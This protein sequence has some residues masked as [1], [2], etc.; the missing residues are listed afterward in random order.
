MGNGFFH[1]AH[2]FTKLILLLFL[3]LA[4]YLVLFGL[5]IFLAIAIY[6]IPAGEVIS[7]IDNNSYEGNIPLLKMLQVL[8]STGLFL[9]PAILAAFLIERRVGD[10]LGLSG[11]P[12]IGIFL[13]ILMLMFAIVPFINY[14]ALLNEKL[15]LPAR[16]SGVMEKINRNDQSQWDLMKAF[17]DTDR[18]GGFLFNLFMIALVPAIGEEFFFRGV[19]QRILAE[20]F[21]N[22][23]VAIW[24][25]A[26]VFSLM[27]YQFMGFIPRIVLGAL[28]GYLF[29]WTGSIWAPVIAH[30]LNNGAAVVQYYFYYRG[31]FPQEPENIGLGDGA[32]QYVL[33]STL[34]SAVILL[35]IRKLGKGSA[36]AQLPGTE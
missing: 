31:N 3:M 4:S 28:F 5:G 1:T 21:R 12:G 20:W 9:I 30:F 32:L 14:V 35:L 33:F 23:H 25:T 18:F 27:H 2:P 19:L 16:W 13:L 22:N 8:Y 17:L 15:S 36:D 11:L 34:V 7:I 24:A 26:F 6:H 10:Y 29:I